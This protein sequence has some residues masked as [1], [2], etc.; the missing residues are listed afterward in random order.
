LA[1]RRPFRA[2]P[3][4]I[5]NDFKNPRAFQVGLGASARSRAGHRRLDGSYVKTDRLQRNRELNLPVPRSR[6]N[7]PAQRP[8]SAS[9]RARRGR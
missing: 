3:I 8:S 2:Q 5:D 7:D 4:S 1:C 9:P 6:A